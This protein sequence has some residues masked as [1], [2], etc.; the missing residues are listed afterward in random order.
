MHYR[1]ARRGFTLIEMLIVMA[2]IAILAGL[3]LAGVQRARA[4]ARR[5]SAA[6]DIS[7]LSAACAKFKQDFGFY[8]PTHVTIQPGNLIVPFKIPTSAP[9]V[10]DPSS[11]NDQSYMLLKRMFPRW[12]PSGSINVGGQFSGDLDNN[13]ALVYFL[14]GPNLTGWNTADPQVAAT[15]TSKKGPYFDFPEARLDRLTTIKPR[16]QDPWGTPF[17]YFRT[18]N[19]ND[20][21]LQSTA[22]G[23][24]TPYKQAGRDVNQN[25][26]QIVSA[27]A[28]KTFGSGGAWSPGGI[29]YT[30]ADVGFDDVA[31][32]NQGAQLGV[33]VQAN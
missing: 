16:F 29:G 7:Q 28:D 30:P 25:S 2:I 3:L 12:Q 13:E 26:V 27:G 6:N 22:F 19:G 24:V 31:N 14:G 8:P 4:I 10:P 33:Q 11:A 5:T 21:D 9:I 17:A 15:G 20:Y 1:P 32:F 18:V 23:G